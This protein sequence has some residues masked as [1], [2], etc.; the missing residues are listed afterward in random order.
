MSADSTGRAR[1]AILLPDLRGGGAERVCIYLANAF[2]A[3]G[4][5]VDLVLALGGGPLETLLHPRIRLVTLKSRRVR[6]SLWPLSRYLRGARPTLVLANMWPL[7]ILAL[8]ANWLSRS[9]ARVVGIEHTTWSRA[10]LA[11]DS[12]RRLWIRASM[13]LIYP[14]LSHRIAVSKGAAADLASFAG[15]TEESVNVIYNPITGVA[16]SNRIAIPA[17]LPSKWTSGRAR[18]LAVGTLKP[19]KDFSTLL[20]A[21]AMLR[22]QVDARLLILGEGEERGQLEAQIERLGLHEAVDLPGFVIDTHAYY[23]A[24]DLYVMSSLGEGL[25]TVLVE[26]LEQGVPIIST[27][28]PSGPREILEDGKYG[29]LVPVGDAVALARAMEEALSRT[30]DRE[31]LKR[32]AKDFSVDKAADAYLDLLLPGWRERSTT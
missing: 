29:T 5:D 28:C 17:S 14:S 15:L 2:V 24:A 12:I 1:I 23:R 16:L 11:I 22:Q 27:D 8:L 31:A 19:I 21:L 3:R 20:Q 30:H 4:F 7:P 13:R 32:R 25:P 10:E 26:A 6:Y 9:N 18:L